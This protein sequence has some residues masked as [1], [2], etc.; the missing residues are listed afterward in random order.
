M[1]KILLVLGITLM[2]FGILFILIMPIIGIILILLSIGLIY[3]GICS[4]ETISKKDISALLFVSLACKLNSSKQVFLDILKK[5]DSYKELNK[6][7]KDLDY[8]IEKYVRNFATLNFTPKRPI[9]PYIAAGIGSSIAGPA[10]AIISY[11]DANNANEE[12]LKEL[13]VVN[14]NHSEYNQSLTDFESCFYGIE[15]ILLK[16]DTTKK[17]WLSIKEET[18]KQ[19][20]ER[21]KDKFNL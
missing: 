1:K 14:K 6:L 9:N 18:L 21:L 15:D 10:G 3:K 19:E 8:Y 2:C 20:T 16:N 4:K 7:F 5:E 12:Y 17:K 11:N 13:D